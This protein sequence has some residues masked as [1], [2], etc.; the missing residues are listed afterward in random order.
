VI[1]K[2]NI[3]Q[4]W[5]YHQRYVGMFSGGGG[6]MMGAMSGGQPGGGSFGGGGFGGGGGMAGMNMI[7]TGNSGGGAV[8]SAVLI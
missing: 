4:H 6:G 7:R 3:Q 2:A 8:T 5:L 1:A